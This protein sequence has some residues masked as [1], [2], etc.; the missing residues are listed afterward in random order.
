MVNDDSGI[1]VELYRHTD[2][3]SV[4]KNQ[5]ESDSNLYWTTVPVRCEKH[6]LFA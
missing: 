6:E 3:L 4:S 5:K 2:L 1:F